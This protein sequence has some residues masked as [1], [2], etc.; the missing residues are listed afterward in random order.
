MDMRASGQQ[1]VHDL[2]VARPCRFH[3]SGLAV[4]ASG[5]NICP[6]PQQIFD[7]SRITF[8]G[9][10][11]EICL[12]FRRQSPPDGYRGHQEDRGKNGQDCPSNS[13]LLGENTSE[14]KSH[15]LEWPNQKVVSP[16][17]C[18]GDSQGFDRASQ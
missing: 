17:L 9:K 8:A 18:R 12:Y 6:L 1:L 5:V 13:S 11:Q 4:L 16:R 15:R 2:S 3:K 7:F 14:E 10:S